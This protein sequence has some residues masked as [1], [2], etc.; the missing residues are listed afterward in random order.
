[1]QHHTIDH[2]LTLYIH[3][4]YVTYYFHLQ[5]WHSRRSRIQKQPPELFLKILQMSQE[6]TCAGSLI[7]KVASLQACN[8]IKNSVISCKIWEILENTYFE[9]HLDDCFCVL[10]T[11]SYIDFYNSLQYAFFSFT[12]NFLITQLKNNITN[13]A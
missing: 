4:L 7:Y 9:E 1:M 11:S 13:D 8:A 3:Y 2:T 5:F 12:R 10:I 6:N